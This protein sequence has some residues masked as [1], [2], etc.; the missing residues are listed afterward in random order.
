MPTGARG[1]ISDFN[2]QGEKIDLSVFGFAN[3]AA[4]KAAAV[5]EPNSVVIDLGTHDLTLLGSSS[6]TSVR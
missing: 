3:F 2:I 6:A 5:D 4:L 1:N